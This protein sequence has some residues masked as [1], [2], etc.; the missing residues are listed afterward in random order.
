MNNKRP[1]TVASRPLIDTASSDLVLVG[2]RFVDDP[3]HRSTILFLLRQR[4]G[5]SA[6]LFDLGS[7][8]HEVDRITK[9]SLRQI[10]D[11]TREAL[12]PLILP[13]KINAVSVTAKP[14]GAGG[15]VE[16]RL[17]WL[18][19]RGEHSSLTEYLSIGSR[20]TS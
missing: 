4:R 6:A 5:S 3:T 2:G 8:F 14:A 11:M 19:T 18:D 12:S 1:P 16:L 17:D 10:E 9:Q 15:T 20:S 13:K 7:R